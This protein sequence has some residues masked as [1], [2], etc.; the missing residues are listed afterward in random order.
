MRQRIYAM[1]VNKHPGIA[2]RYHKLYDGSTGLLKIVSWAY[3]L[4]LNIAYHVL[5]MRFLGR[6][7][8]ADYY[9]GKRLNCRESESSSFKHLTV[10]EYVKEFEKYD[11]VSFDVFDTLIFRP[12]SDPRDLFYILGEELEICDFK[13][14]R[15]WC[16][17]DARKKCYEKNAHME[18]NLEDIWRNIRKDVVISE[19]EGQKLEID[20][21][22]RLCY[23]NPFM[24]KV[25]EEL[26]KKRKR[27]IVVSDMYLPTEVITKMLEGAGFV[28][29][30]RIF[31]SNEYRVSKADGKLY[32]IVLDELNLDKEQIV[33]VGDSEHSDV[34]MAKKS[35]LRVMP[36]ANINKNMLLYRPYD[37]SP[38]IGS[39]YRAIV[40]AYLYNGLNDFSMEYEYGY[41]YGGLFV[42]GYCR[43]IHEY[44]ES[45]NLDKL[46]FL[47]RDGDTLLRVYELMYPDDNVEYAFWS[48]KAATK[49]MAAYDR[50]DYF[51]RFIYHKINQKVSIRKALE[52]MELEALLKELDEW[53]SIWYA[54]EDKSKNERFRDLKPDDELTDK[55]GF[56]LRRFIEAKWEK[57][58]EVYEPQNRAAKEYYRGKL[59]GCR[60]AA[61]I[62]IGWA[63]SGAISLDYLVNNVWEM[64]CNIT[65]IIAGTNTIN[66]SEPDSTDAFLQSEKLVSYL[67][68]SA[69]NRDLYK[70]HD[71]NKD[72]NV[73]WELLLSSPTQQFVGFYEGEDGVELRYGKFDENQDGI[74]EVQRGICDFA[75]QYYEHFKEYPYMF[76][77][78][79]RDAYAP[80]LA[81]TGNNE[82]Y[83]KTIERKF[84]LII[85]V[86]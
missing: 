2:Y 67:Y 51:R 33:H 14:I 58:M 24:L 30:E 10:D 63:G 66:N 52:S 25:W 13:N 6:K 59:A 60:K 49:L 20:T 55:N 37:M 72:Y 77:I 54:Y 79:G 76:N 86:E 1:L 64:E 11:V 43:F 18:I 15:T 9:E 80:M 27:L 19:G 23:A 32:Q 44:Y 5:F 17:W 61:A 85:N 69:I 50:H 71:P 29:A 73:F 82:K 39:A 3:L 70:K 8:A 21:E 7:P 78:S 81:A 74:R 75:K 42:V 62:D 16:E 28:G 68:S 46:L 65:G 45:H 12:F 47:S 26:R 53:R 38:I 22:L 31:V 40:S 57:V 36:Y 48:R 35:G 84:D 83:L 34:K 4:W 41:I 56:L